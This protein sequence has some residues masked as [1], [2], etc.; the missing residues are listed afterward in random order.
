MK[1]K[2][3]DKSKRTDCL[4]NQ[5]ERE[6]VVVL[7]VQSVLGGFGF[8]EALLQISSKWY[9]GVLSF[10]QKKERERERNETNKTKPRAATFY[11]SLRIVRHPPYV[12]TSMVP[13]AVPQ[14]FYRDKKYI[15]L[16]FISLSLFLSLILPHQPLPSLAFLFLAIIMLLYFFFSFRYLQC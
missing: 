8:K 6:E 13:S 7:V 11:A 5:H 9:F 14:P 12:L 2:I 4:I 16:I 3:L 1:G 15:Y 10:K